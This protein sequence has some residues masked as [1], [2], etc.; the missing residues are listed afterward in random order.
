MENIPRFFN[1]YQHLKPKKNLLIQTQQVH[2]K[3]TFFGI[4]SV[5]DFS[6]SHR[7]IN[8]ISSMVMFANNHY[9]KNNKELFQ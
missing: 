6:N 1:S 2:L 3:A 9:M 7:G 8:R 4:E 5:E